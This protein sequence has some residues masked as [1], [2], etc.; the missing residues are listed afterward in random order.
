MRN[1]RSAKCCNEYTLRC[2]F[3]SPSLT[4]SR[5]PTIDTTRSVRS[6]QSRDLPDLDDYPSFRSF[7]L[8]SRIYLVIKIP[9]LEVLYVCTQAIPRVELTALIISSPYRGYESLNPLAVLG[10][11]IDNF[12]F[13]AVP[14]G[15]NYPK[16][17]INGTL[18]HCD[19][20]HWTNV[21]LGS[22]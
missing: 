9:I 10:D 7:P 19:W 11:R 22:G 16:E 18:R 5:I 17:W 3:P 6:G 8:L 4:R 1:P 13:P 2:K 20:S 12:I 15:R 14:C 21:R